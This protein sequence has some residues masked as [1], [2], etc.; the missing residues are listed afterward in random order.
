MKYFWGL[1]GPGNFPGY[2]PTALLQP[3]L[4]TCRSGLSCGFT[5]L[6]YLV[7]L[8]VQGFMVLENTFMWMSCIFAHVWMW[9]PEVC[10]SCLTVFCQTLLYF[11]SQ[12]LWLNLELICLLDSQCHKVPPSLPTLSARLQRLLCAKFLFGY[13]A[14]KFISFGLHKKY[15]MC[16]TILPSGFPDHYSSQALA[17]RMNLSGKLT[18]R[19]ENSEQVLKNITLR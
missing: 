4:P 15:F 5:L 11:L 14:S 16:W 8:C 17:S 18:Y 7:F 10:V 3:P 12:N 19:A 1:K 9:R 13:W 2:L 6:P